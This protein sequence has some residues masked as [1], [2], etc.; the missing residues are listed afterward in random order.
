MLVGRLFPDPVI[1]VIW[2]GTQR[3]GVEFREVADLGSPR[4]MVGIGLGVA[5]DLGQ[6]C[7]WGS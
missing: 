2:A 5:D 6:V 4:R 7:G 3:R 1:A